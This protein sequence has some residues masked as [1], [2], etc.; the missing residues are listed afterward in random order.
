MARSSPDR[1]RAR[2]GPAPIPECQNWDRLARVGRSQSPLRHPTRS[3]LPGHKRHRTT[4]CRDRGAHGRL[5]PQC[6][7]SPRGLSVNRSKA[8]APPHPRQEQHQIAAGER[9]APLRRRE[10]LPREMHEDRA[11]S[12]LHAWPRVVVENDDHIIDIVGAPKSFCACRI[13]VMDVAIVVTVPTASHHPSSGSQRTCRQ[14]VR[15]L[16]D[17]SAR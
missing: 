10:V 15:G 11:A 12:P 16:S 3:P 7:Q 4:R 5:L 17:R 2:T 8:R 1:R 9:D 6:R 13:R 14:P